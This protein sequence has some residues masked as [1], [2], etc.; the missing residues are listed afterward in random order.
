MTGR[1]VHGHGVIPVPQDQ[2]EVVR[3]A[4]RVAPA[5]LAFGLAVGWLIGRWVHR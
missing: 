3:W 5:G 2:R 4:V 1:V